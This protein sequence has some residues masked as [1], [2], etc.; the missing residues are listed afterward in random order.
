MKVLDA[1]LS[2]AQATLDASA[3]TAPR[4]LALP[5]AA[6]TLALNT[7]SVVNVTGLYAVQASDVG[8]LLA[9]SGAGYGFSLDASLLSIGDFVYLAKRAGAIDSV[10]PITVTN[11]NVEARG[12]LQILRQYGIVKATKVDASISPVIA[13]TGDL[14][15]E[16]VNAQ[17]GTAYT[18]V[19]SDE[20]GGTSHS[21]A[22]AITVTIPASFTYVGVRIP[23]RQAAAGIVTIAA[24]SGVTLHSPNGEST[25]AQYDGRVVEQITLNNWVVW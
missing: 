11:A 22:G 23:I 8:K 15:R 14:D 9:V 5:D 7:V 25:N 4:T 24:G 20:F 1:Q 16:S 17:T 3:L 13:L 2:L 21:N 10:C 12:R 18:L 19:A 6:G